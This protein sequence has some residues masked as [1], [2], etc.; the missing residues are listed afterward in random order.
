MSPL[1]SLRY[2]RMHLQLGSLGVDPTNGHIKFW[3]GG[4]GHK[5]F[6][7]DHVNVDRQVGSTFKPFVYATAI[8]EFGISPCTQVHDIAQTI[9]VNDWFWFRLNLG[10]LKTQADTLV[11]T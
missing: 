5:Y 10:H 11:D 9:G 6:Q 2:H 4:T 1:D 7:V 8:A 3:V